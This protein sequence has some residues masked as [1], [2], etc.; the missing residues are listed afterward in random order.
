MIFFSPDEVYHC[1][2]RKQTE[3]PMSTL[4]ATRLPAATVR[5]F[6]AVARAN[7]RTRS[8]ELRV[9]IEKYI[10]DYRPGLAEK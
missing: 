2:M 10:A 4:I 8:A 7:R 9:A 3:D 1:N 6:D 5:A